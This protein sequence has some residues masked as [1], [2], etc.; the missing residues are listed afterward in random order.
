MTGIRI[1]VGLLAVVLLTAAGAGRLAAEDAIVS[2]DTRPSVIQ[3]FLVLEPKGE[4]TGAVIMFPPEEGLV[5]F[6]KSKKGRFKVKR[7][8][9]IGQTI[10]MY[11]ERGFAVAVIEPPSDRMAHGMDTDF[12]K[13]DEH[14]EDLGH[15]IA[16]M[17]DMTGFKPFLV[18][19]CRA[20]HSASS[21]A[22]KTDKARISGVV[23]ASSRSRGKRGSILDAI[24]P[25]R[26]QSRVLFVHHVDD[27]CAGA[28][29]A[30]V[31][32]LAAAFD[33]ADVQVVTVSGGWR[34]AERK[35]KRG[36]GTNGSHKFCGSQDITVKAI[37]DWMAGREVADRLDAGD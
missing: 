31:A 4:V 3:R 1:S 26:L 6:K 32:K 21:V 11:H 28:P 29:Y 14:A 15:V 24:S 33:A 10:G 30:G 8:G 16:H 23:L 19:T 5:Q 22:A 27:D 36:C 25:G 12:R 37:T 20:T 9:W 13:S 34:T 7:G 17:T 35:Q 2:L 18:A